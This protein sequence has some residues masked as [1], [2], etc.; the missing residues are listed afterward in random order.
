MSDKLIE[1]ATA[2]T[3]IILKRN[4]NDML[5]ETHYNLTHWKC[6]SIQPGDD[7]GFRFWI[8]KGYVTNNE[9]IAAELAPGIAPYMYLYE[10]SNALANP[11][12]G[13]QLDSRGLILH[14]LIE[15]NIVNGILIDDPTGT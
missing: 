7:E 12:E 14:W 3:C 10:F 4:D 9:F 1:L 2:E 15:N 8:S 11:P 6:V 13:E 5:E